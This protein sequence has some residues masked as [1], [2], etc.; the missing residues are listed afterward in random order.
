MRMMM[1]EWQNG[2][3]VQEQ[4]SSIEFW[5]FCKIFFEDLRVFSFFFFSCHNYIHFL[6]FRPEQ[7]STAIEHADS[8]LS[9]LLKSVVKYSHKR[10][11]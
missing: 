10:R 8:T 2:R 3:Q 5:I 6:L 1:A 11:I 7:L 9:S 4:A